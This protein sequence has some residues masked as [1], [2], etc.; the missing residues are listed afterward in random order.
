MNIIVETPKGSSIKYH[1][2]MEQNAFAVKRILAAGMLFPFDFG[3]VPHTKGEDGDAL[4]ALL[5]AEFGTFA[6]CHISCRLIGCLQAE[7][8]DDNETIS[9]DRYLLVPEASHLYSHVTSIHH[10]PK[11]LM[12]ELQHFFVA[13]NKAEGKLFKVTGI[14]D[15]EEAY[16]LLKKHHARFID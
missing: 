13:Y 11:A 16:N 14:L 6:G 7:Q 4:D 1:Y 9:N 3:F 12:E 5:I 2:D 15:E 10:L 8:T